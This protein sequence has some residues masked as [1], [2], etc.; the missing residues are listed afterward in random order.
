MLM[1]IVKNYVTDLLQLKSI[2]KSLCTSCDAQ[3]CQPEIPS[4]AKYAAVCILKLLL[5]FEIV[6]HERRGF[7]RVLVMFS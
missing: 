4:F 3:D 7:G 1:K 5:E 6:S 2:R